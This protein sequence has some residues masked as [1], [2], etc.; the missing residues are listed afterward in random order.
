VSTTVTTAEATTTTTETTT[1]E[2]AAAASGQALKDGFT[3]ASGTTI[4]Q[5]PEDQKENTVG[6][7]VYSGWKATLDLTGDL[8]AVADAYIAQVTKNGY[9][10]LPEDK[11]E[12]ESSG[13]KIRYR[14]FT[15]V[16]EV[17][18]SKAVGGKRKTDQVIINVIKSDSGS[19]EVTI[20]VA[21][22][23]TRRPPSRPASAATRPSPLPRPGTCAS[24][25]STN[26]AAPSPTSLPGTCTE[27]HP[28][29][30]HQADRTT[31]RE[32]RLPGRR[33]SPPRIRDRN[34]GPEH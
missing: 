15:G 22:P 11:G 19:G 9:T 27:P 34:Y 1:T 17:P 3:V 29:R 18:N 23:Q 31:Q 5:G 20:N 25:T 14:S 16:K 30:P 13:R 32:A 28:K 33:L 24:S 12:N 6:N 21:S 10:L 7:S 2:A 26:A 4:Y 8:D